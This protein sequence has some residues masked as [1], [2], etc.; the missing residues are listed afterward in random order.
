MSPKSRR[1]VAVV[2]DPDAPI[3]QEILAEAIVRISEGMKKLYASGLNRRAIVLLTANEAKQ[4]Q[5]VVE[6]VLIGLE[7][8]RAAYCR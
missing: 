2:Q 6:A 1:K 4:P 3:E 7:N 5:Y 8:L